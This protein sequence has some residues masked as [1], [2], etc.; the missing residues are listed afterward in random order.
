MFDAEQRTIDYITE[1]AN[2]MLKDCT[3]MT[4]TFPINVSAHVGPGTIGLTVCPKINGKSVA[5][6]IG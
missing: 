2:Q 1:A 6:F 3:N 5:S 4:G